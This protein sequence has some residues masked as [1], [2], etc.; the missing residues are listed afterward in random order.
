MDGVQARRT[1]QETQRAGK[2]DLSTQFNQSPTPW[3]GG[4]YHTPQIVTDITWGVMHGRA[5]G[6]GVVRVGDETRRQL[7][8]SNVEEVAP[9]AKTL[10]KDQR[11]RQR[12]VLPM[13]GLDGAVQ[14]MDV[15]LPFDTDS[16][17][18]NGIG[19]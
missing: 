9:S 2:G 4:E 10:E 6:K 12:V 3:A 19:L 16:S 7:L 17:H 8:E 1:R 18:P 14:H 11:R 15:Y 5:R 13:K